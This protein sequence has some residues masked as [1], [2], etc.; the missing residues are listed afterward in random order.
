MSATGR[1]STIPAAR[2]EEHLVDLDVRE[3]GE[4]PANVSAGVVGRLEHLGYV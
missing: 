2:L 1:P 4:D 3:H